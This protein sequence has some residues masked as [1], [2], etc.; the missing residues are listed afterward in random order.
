M[1]LAA[2]QS[3]LLALTSRLHTIEGNAQSILGDK[4]RLAND[5]ELVYKKYMQ[6]L[7]ATVIKTVQYD[8]SKGKTE[9]VNGSVNNLLR[10]QAASTTSGEVFYVQ[11][12]AT[13]EIYLPA[14]IGSVYNS[15]INDKANFIEKLSRMNGEVETVN[16]GGIIVE[17]F[18]NRDYYGQLF[19]AI[20]AAGGWTEISEINAKNPSWVSNMIRNGEVI[21]TSFDSENFVLSKTSPSLNTSLRQITDDTTYKVASQEYETAMEEI[22]EKDAI[23][24]KKLN[25]METEKEAIEQ[26]MDSLKEVMYTNV[27]NHFK[28]FT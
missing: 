8:T 2:S 11:S 26:E 6:A 28:V 25:M 15:N 18:Y 16:E 22:N 10:Y 21:L 19:N 13:G 17:R 7:D 5:T 20:S 24:D 27:D 9:W 12:I 3:R 14:S 23:F 4:K 1:G